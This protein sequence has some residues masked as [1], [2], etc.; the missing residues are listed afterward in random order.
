MLFSSYS[1]RAE[2]VTRVHK[3]PGLRSIFHT[4][5]RRQ[6]AFPEK[7]NEILR[8]NQTF[9]AYYA[10]GIANS[11]QRRNAH[12]ISRFP[13]AR[14]R[15]RTIEMTPGPVRTAPTTP[16]RTQTGTMF[17]TMTPSLGGMTTPSP[18]RTPIPPPTPPTSLPETFP[19]RL[20][21][22]CSATAVSMTGTATCW[23]AK[24]PS[25]PVQTAGK[26][27]IS[28]PA[29]HAAYRPNRRYA[30]FRHSVH[31][32]ARGFSPGQTSAIIR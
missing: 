18:P 2:S 31:Q 20:W 19:A 4:F 11:Q 14:S 23:T 28:Y 10:M 24:I 5:G 26:A 30:A 17:P 8:E 1:A 7:A 6:G 3:A 27:V 32:A 15:P 13:A 16:F 22:G 9:A 12:E 21:T 29:R 25:P